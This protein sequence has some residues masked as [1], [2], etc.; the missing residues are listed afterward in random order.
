MATGYPALDAYAPEGVAT[1]TL[2]GQFVG[3]VVFILLGIVPDYIVSAILK[4][5]GMLRVP[6]AVQEK[7]L[8]VVKVP[9]QA[10]PEGM[11]SPASEDV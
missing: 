7:G 1:I 3:S 2:W 9:A 11:N 4:S 10:Y 5:L 6:D 8:D